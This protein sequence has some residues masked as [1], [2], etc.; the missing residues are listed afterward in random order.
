MGT[1]IQDRSRRTKRPMATATFST[2]TGTGGYTSARAR[3]P[4]RDYKGFPAYDGIPD[5]VLIATTAVTAV[6]GTP[7][8]GTLYDPGDHTV[9][10]VQAHVEGLGDES[11]Q[12]VIDETQRILDVERAGQN[13][14][15]LVSWLAARDGVV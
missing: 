12:A 13:R 3:E 11:D 2:G 10:E 7:I 6:G 1:R 14:T 5:P 4:R 9:A 15:T 8:G